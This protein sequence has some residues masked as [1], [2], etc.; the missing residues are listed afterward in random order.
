MDSSECHGVAVL[1]IKGD[2]I[3]ADHLTM[4]GNLRRADRVK[5]SVPVRVT[6]QDSEGNHKFTRAKV[7]D[8]SD[9]GIRI[10]L[11]EAVPVRGAVGLQAESLGLRCSGSVRHCVRTGIKYI[12]GI[13]FIG[14]VSWKRPEA[15]PAETDTAVNKV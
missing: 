11:P 8:I 13:A 15:A 1:S 14:T 9:T 2:A 7:L 3:S 12:A 4:S 5:N 6:W 10:E